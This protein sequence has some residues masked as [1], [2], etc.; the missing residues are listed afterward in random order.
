M[1]VCFET[2]GCRLSRAEALQQEA[3][4]VARGMEIT[5]SHADADLIIVRGCSVTRR[6]QR[7]CEKL[8]EH[9]KAKYP[10]K[11]VLVTG[12]LPDKT[13]EKLAQL[14]L[15]ER[16]PE[17]VPMRTARAY[18][19]VQD[20][21]NA[22]CSFC[23]VPQFRGNSVSIPVEEVLDRAKRF[24]EVGY[25]EIVLTGC[26]LT[27]Y[28]WEGKQLP[29]LLA[30]ISDAVGS[31]ARLRIGSLEP[32]PMAREVISLMAERE[33]FCRFLHLPIQ[34]GSDRILKAMRRPYTLADVSGLLEMI[35]ADLPSLGLG[36]DLMTGFPGEFEADYIKTEALMR[37]YPLSKA[38]IFPYSERPNTVAAMLQP[39]VE[40]EIRHQRAR[41]LAQIGEENYTRF[42]KSF[43]G[44]TV[45]IVIEDEKR[46]SGWTSEYLPARLLPIFI[47]SARSSRQWKRRQRARIHVKEVREGELFGQPLY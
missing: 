41:Q 8:I 28:A 5:R 33:N 10:L 6:A 13:S 42:L 19:K 9:L 26:N 17:A 31:S 24:V 14:Y 35:A 29:E 30:A 15:K 45:E 36:C 39:V 25:E 47:D 37:R 12:C 2:F 21:C 20:G 22:R 27:H 1:R 40:R 4:C 34:S 43:V 18:L 11:R 44:K 32:V 38:H 23:I 3:E 7:D 46:M 16:H